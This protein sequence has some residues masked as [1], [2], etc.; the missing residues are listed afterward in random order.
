MSALMRIFSSLF[1]SCLNL[2]SLVLTYLTLSIY[3]C[4]NLRG[5]LPVVPRNK[6]ATGDFRR[7][8]L[9]AAKF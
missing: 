7:F 3:I 8:S 9:C 2:P 6:G 5:I 4:M 1:S